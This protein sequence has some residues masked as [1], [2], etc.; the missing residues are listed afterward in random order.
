MG[1]G[2]AVILVVDDDPLIRSTLRMM[3]EIEGHEVI[4]A[5][6]GRRA[7]QIV[8]RRRPDL[9][10]TDIL[11]PEQEGIETIISLRQAHKDLKILAISGGGRS[12]QMEFLRL[13]GKFG[14]DATLEKPFDR[15][16]FL[17]AIRPLLAAR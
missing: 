5:E 17:A 14:A 1:G 2:M 15:S 4:D 6:N 7:E 13:A 12:R 9:M 11:M 10:V 3:L 8:A 16:T